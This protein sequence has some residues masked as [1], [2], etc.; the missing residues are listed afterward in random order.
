MTVMQIKLPEIF[1]CDPS[2]CIVVIAQLG[3]FIYFCK[4][5]QNRLIHKEKYT[6]FGTIRKGAIMGR[7]M[8]CK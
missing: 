3:D 1:C 6:T 8:W 4:Q 2:S 5:T 7:K